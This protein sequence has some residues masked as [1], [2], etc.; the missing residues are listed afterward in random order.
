MS[1]PQTSYGFNKKFERQLVTVLCQD[2]ETF[3]RI[4][5]DMDP[6]LLDDEDA[7]RALQIAHLLYQET[8]RG[9]SGHVIVLQ[10]M[11]RQKF[12]GKF[13]QKHID[14]V[15]DMFEA[16]EDAGLPEPDDL[17]DQVVPIIRRIIQ[18]EAVRIGIDQVNKED[19]DLSGVSELIEKATDL[20]KIDQSIGTEYDDEAYKAIAAL[21]T[22][23]RLGSGIEE[24][25]IALQGGF[26][27][28]S[29]NY[30]LG[31]AGDGKSMALVQCAASGIMSGL[32]VL[33]VTLEVSKARTMLR[34]MSNL[35]NI[36]MEKLK[37]IDGKFEL[38]QRRMAEVLAEGGRFRCEYMTP[39]V[40]QLKDIKGLCRRSEEHD[41]VKYQVIIID[42]ADRLGYDSKKHRNDYKGMLEVYESFRIW[43]EGEDRW[44]LTASQAIRRTS[45]SGKRRKLDTDDAADSQNKVRVTDGMITL[46]VSED[47]SEI[48]FFVGKARTGA[49]RKTV[50][51]L[52][53]KWAFAQIV[54]VERPW[55]RRTDIPE[56]FEEADRQGRLQMG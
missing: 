11:A 16:C 45:K 28:G 24:L 2:P 32:N 6:T 26:E 29:M 18:D 30:F 15:C 5:P 21:S 12:E 10:R 7:Q 22:I 23:P 51:P 3:G 39:T 17:V 41:G 47:S 55:G 9:P 27:S 25:D 49:A 31:G 36:P 46:N 38:G 14:R 33:Y 19:G 35:T 48:T 34:L 37:L 50:G 44:G 42:Y 13:R 53:T 52:P 4:A 40:T 43:M 54:H 20:G 56:E 8:G 1:A